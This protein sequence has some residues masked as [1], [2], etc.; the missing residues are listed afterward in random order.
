MCQWCSQ[1]GPRGVD[2]ISTLSY[3]ISATRESLKFFLCFALCSVSS[4]PSAISSTVISS[5][6]ST[7][8]NLLSAFRSA[9]CSLLSLSL[10]RI[11]RTQPRLGCADGERKQ[12]KAH[13]K[14]NCIAWKR[15]MPKHGEAM[16]S[17]STKPCVRGTLYSGSLL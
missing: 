6:L 16:W 4:A 8:S 9:L 13:G 5:Q 7:L 17:I 3:L 1:R 14:K 2:V 15:A 12:R 10:W 11:R